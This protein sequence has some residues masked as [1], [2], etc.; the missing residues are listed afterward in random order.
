[1]EKRKRVEDSDESF[2]PAKTRTLDQKCPIYSSDSSTKNVSER[3]V[4]PGIPARALRGHRSSSGRRGARNS[5]S[6]TAAPAVHLQPAAVP[7]VSTAPAPTI[8]AAWTT[9]AVPELSPEQEQAAADLVTKEVIDK[10]NKVR[11]EII[12]QQSIVFKKKIMADQRI[13]ADTSL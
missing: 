2:M 4:V 11:L 1:M 5:I 10:T 9:Q 13:Q 6:S 8:S 12:E 7:T 3:L